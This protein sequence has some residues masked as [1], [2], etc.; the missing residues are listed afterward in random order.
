MII[1]FFSL[2]LLLGFIQYQWIYLLMFF[3]WNPESKYH[4]LEAALAVITALA[5]G[6][7]LD[8]N[9]SGISKYIS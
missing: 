8:I 3:P 2:S 7:G 1:V 9:I 4:I 5:A 6:T